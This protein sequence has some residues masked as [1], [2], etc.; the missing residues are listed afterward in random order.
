MEVPRPGV[1]FKLPLPPRSCGSARSFNPLS[2]AGD[3]TCTSTMTRAIQWMWL[4]LPVAV[5]L[6]IH[7]WR[8][9]LERAQCHL[10]GVAVKKVGPESSM[11]VELDPVEGMGC[12]LS[13]TQK[14]G[15]CWRATPDWQGTIKTGQLVLLGGILDQK[16]KRNTVVIV[17]KIGM[18]SMDWMGGVVWMFVSWCG[19]FYAGYVDECSCF[20]KCTLEYLGV[21]GHH[22]Y[23]PTLRRVQKKLMGI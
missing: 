16:G 14:S 8:G 22:V 17:C 1:E 3:R 20:W 5:W 21:V 23:S 13:R 10:S 9:A 11:Q 12:A 2:W 4:T 7:S 19:E 15:K 6:A 18:D